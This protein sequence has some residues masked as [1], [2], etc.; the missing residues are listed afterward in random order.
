MPSEGSLSPAIAQAVLGEVLPGYRVTGV[1]PRTGGEVNGVYEVRGAA[2]DEPVAIKVYTS[3]GR[4][5]PWLSKLAKE[6]Y[7]YRL[8]ARAGVRDIPRVL[9]DEPAGVPALPRPFLVMTLLAGQAL[10]TVGDGLTGA[11]TERV[12]ER[13]GQLLAEVHRIPAASWGYISTGV[14]DVQ[15]SNTAYMAGQFATK[16]QRFRD[17]GGDPALG[18]AIEAHAA[19]RAYLFA[20][21]ER[22]VLC[23]ND[24]HDG[25]VLAVRTGEGWRVSGYVDVE[26]A[27]AADPLLDLARTHY[28]ALREDA[29]K[30]R[31]FLRGYGPLPPDW[32]ER[33]ALYQLHHALEFW[34]WSAARGRRDALPAIRADIEQYL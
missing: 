3:R 31:A 27:V 13:M 32:T 17:L 6:V 15:P 2:G 22:P 14:I 10:A 24:F 8:L 9:R 21:C 34:N 26:N 12:Y 16:L 18:R 4:T 25:N 20:A 11:E 5:R 23:H 33:L 7:V 19:G 29:V 1:L 30:R 28:C